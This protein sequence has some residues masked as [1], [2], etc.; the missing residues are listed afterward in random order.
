MFKAFQSNLLSL[1]SH[2]LRTP[3]T[4]IMNAITL[5]EQG[6][7]QTEF[8]SGELIGMASRNARRLNYTLASLLDLAAIE[9]GAFHPR[10]RE[11]ELSRVIDAQ[12]RDPP[13]SFRE[14]KLR[15]VTVPPAPH[16]DPELE[17]V[18]ADPQKFGR[19]IETC[20]ELIGGHAQASSEI[21]L[22]TGVRDVHLEFNLD[23][24]QEASWKRSWEV[25]ASPNA[26]SVFAGVMQEEHGFLSRGSEGLGHELALAREILRVHGGRLDCEQKKDRIRLSLELP[27]LSS[28]TGLSAVIGSRA[29]EASTG[30]GSVALALVR[31]PPKKSTEEFRAQV[32]ECLFRSS[33]AVYALPE[34]KQLAIVL[35][36]CKRGDAPGLLSRIEKKLNLKLAF[37][38]ATCPEEGAEPDL[39]IELAQRRLAVV[40]TRQ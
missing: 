19:A 27:K 21:R 2:E 26:L 13:P 36:D 22:D 5:L 40:S 38:V 1:I 35:N 14:R 28:M 16:P 11:I 30:L 29:Y 18:L 3:L 17:P 37:G 31:V 7:D 23:P 15:L 20:L 33:D 34:L 10:L 39:L 4:G 12:F 32:R 6:A 8:K 9:T 25:A 24:A